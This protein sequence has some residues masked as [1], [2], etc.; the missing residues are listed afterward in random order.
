MELTFTFFIEFTFG[1][2]TSIALLSIYGIKIKTP[3]RLNFDLIVNF[4]QKISCY[5]N[6]VFSNPSLRFV[7]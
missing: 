7:N 3:I 2:F 5:V 4:F 6:F 1:V